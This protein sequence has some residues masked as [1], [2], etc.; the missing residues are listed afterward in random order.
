MDNLGFRTA[1]L[2]FGLQFTTVLR[3]SPEYTPLV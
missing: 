1:G 2:Q 3:G